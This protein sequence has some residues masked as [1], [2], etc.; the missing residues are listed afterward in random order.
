MCQLTM[1]GL[2]LVCAHERGSAFLPFGLR[3][4]HPSAHPYLAFPPRRPERRLTLVEHLPVAPGDTP[5]LGRDN[6]VY[7]E[8]E[9]AVRNEPVCEPVVSLP[10]FLLP[11]FIYRPLLSLFHSCVPS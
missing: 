4:L 2:Q 3:R 5:I 6:V 9:P 11:L 7:A 8:R 1:R 10:S